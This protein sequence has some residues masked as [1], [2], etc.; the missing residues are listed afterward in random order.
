MVPVMLIAD[1]EL[2]L[3]RIWVEQYSTTGIFAFWVSQM[4]NCVQLLF[5]DFILIV[6]LPWR[7]AAGFHG[8]FLRVCGHGHSL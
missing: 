6:W 3:P 1:M 5:Q 7:R 2:E 8:L 4:A